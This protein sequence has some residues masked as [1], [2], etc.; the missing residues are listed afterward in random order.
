MRPCLRKTTILY[1]RSSGWQSFKTFIHFSCKKAGDLN[2]KK[3][4]FVTAVVRHNYCENNGAA[5]GLCTGR[6]PVSVKMQLIIKDIE[7][8]YDSNAFPYAS[9][10][11]C[12]NAT[13][14]GY[15]TV[16]CEEYFFSG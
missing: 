11:H 10:T 16:D 5:A 7:A 8:H 9:N 14:D 12:S 3:N 15:S 6:K 4:S 2:V 1:E 13:I